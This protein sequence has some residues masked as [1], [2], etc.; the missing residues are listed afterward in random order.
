MDEL[1]PLVA[2]ECESLARVLDTLTDAEWD[3]PSLCQGWRVR[4]V[5]AHVTMPGRYTPEQFGAEMA[6]A[7]GDFG[8]L[9]NLVA[10]RD[11]DLPTSELV[12]ALR[13]EQMQNWAPPGGG[14]AGALSH[15]VI[16]GC[17]A[18]AAL[19]R[20]RAAGDAAA[21]IVL[22]AL[23]AGD[24]RLFDV[25]LSGKRLVADDLDFSYGQGSEIREHSGQL[26]A[27]L[28]RRTLPDGR[29]LAK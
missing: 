29:S 2:A 16:H 26:V 3:A 20:P 27:L 28:A 10:A 7:A 21:R 14:F 12:A 18:T 22:D 11:A 8:A 5:V 6:A 23:V 25:D 17:D 9:S 15:V 1:Q 19:G 4:E 24:G 13:T